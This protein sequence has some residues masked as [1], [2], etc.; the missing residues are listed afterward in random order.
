VVVVVVVI[1]VVVVVV[2]IIGSLVFILNHASLLIFLNFLL[3]LA[4]SQKDKYFS[5]M[6][7]RAAEE[8]SE[9]E[10]VAQ[11]TL[12]K[13]TFIPPAD[14]TLPE[15]VE[16]IVCMIM[17]HSL[18]CKSLICVCMYVCMYVCML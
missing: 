4:R 11:D 1:F 2:V 7:S 14:M 17:W 9:V 8:G 10:P 18:E 16:V 15:F 6:S 3:Q 12:H 5:E 13:R